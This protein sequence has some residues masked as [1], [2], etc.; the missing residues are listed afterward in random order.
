MVPGTGQVFGLPVGT[1]RGTHVDSEDL[2]LPEYLAEAQ[3]TVSQT[4]RTGKSRPRDT[5]TS[6]K[7]RRNPCGSIT[8]PR[9][10][11]DRSGEP[12]RLVG[13]TMDITG[14]KQAEEALRR[15]EEEFHIIFEHAAIGMVLVDPEGHLLRC[16]PAFC[17]IVG[18]TESDLPSL[19]F[20]KI[21]HP[22]DLDLTRTMYREVV[23][24]NRDRYQIRK[25]YVRPNG[26]IRSARVTVSALR[27]ND[28]ELKYCVVMVEDIT[29]RELAEHTL[30]RSVRTPVAHPGRRTTSHRPRSARFYF[31]GNDCTPGL[32][33]GALM[34]VRRSLPEKPHKRKFAESLALAKRVAREIRTFS[35]LLHPPMLN[36]LGLWSAMQMFVEEFATTA[37]SA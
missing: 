13:L 10:L 36:E 2:I 25:R 37:G 35:Y 1:V 34:A 30:L 31:A 3:A 11:L 18:Y 4:L 21:S 8:R 22:E 19:T 26:E 24:G 17:S 29:S 5:D 9:F 33:L 15:S 20:E 23:R 14:R 32:N 16:N 27:A 6:Q 12:L 28:A 7:R